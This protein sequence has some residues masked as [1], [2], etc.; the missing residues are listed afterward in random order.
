M[1]RKNNGK[2]YDSELSDFYADKFSGTDVKLNVGPYQVNSNLF[3]M[4][5]KN[6]NLNSL[7]ETND[8]YLAS[9]MK[10]ELNV[11]AEKKWNVEGYNG[12]I[13]NN[14]EKPSI[15]NLQA[16]GSSNSNINNNDKKTDNYSGISSQDQ[17]GSFD[18][19]ASNSMNNK[20]L[21]KKKEEENEPN[22]QKKKN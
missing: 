16:I 19:Y 3:S 17:K 4:P 10:T 9:D 6:T 7:Y 12:E 14:S 8:N 1:N 22:T 11:R 5:G 15:N 13:K 2:Q 21:N 18:Y 20:Y